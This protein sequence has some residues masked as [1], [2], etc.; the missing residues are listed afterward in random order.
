M[1]LRAP[2]ADGSINE[3]QH[4]FHALLIHGFAPP[5]SMLYGP[6]EEIAVGVAINFLPKFI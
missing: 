3:D 1:H 4:G 5:H 2:V 6:A